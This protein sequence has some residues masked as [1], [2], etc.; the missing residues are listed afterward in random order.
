MKATD[1]FKRTIQAHLEQVA[2]LDDLFLV[3]LRNPS[4]NID[5]CITYI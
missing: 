3:K 4:K 1:P 2:D 5:D